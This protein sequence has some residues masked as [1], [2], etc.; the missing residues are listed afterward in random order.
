V[1]ES[2][3]LTAAQMREA[4]WRHYAG[5]CA[6]LFEVS[7]NLKV[8]EV[9]VLGEPPIR[10]HRR[11][12]IDVLTVNNARKTGIGPL[13]LLAIEIKVSRGD[14]FA[15]I[16]EPE[17][18]ARW[19]EVAHR[20]AYAVPAGLVQPEEVPAGSGLM[21]IS[22]SPFPGAYRYEVHWRTRARYAET[23]SIPAWLTL[24]FAYRMS[25]AEAKLRGLA[26]VTGDV[27][28]VSMDDLRAA[29]ASTRERNKLLST[30]LDRALSE[31][32]EWRT[33]FA[34]GGHL[35]CMHCC[36]PVKPKSVRRGR[37]TG[38]RHVSREHEAPCAEIRNRVDRWA[39]IE[40]AD[41]LGEDIP[42]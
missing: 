24:A 26:G 20:H 17:K 11:R 30:Q 8:E 27:A 23:P 41:D 16:R 42:A 14:F 31:A 9:P 22:R 38:W 35:P 34:A 29:L 21:V 4:L 33:A 12:R 3:S 19:R 37:F 6:V 28:D 39:E 40:P 15:D 5:R 2:P 13:D 25:A 18:Q 1:I 36:Q 7:T 10:L 32:R